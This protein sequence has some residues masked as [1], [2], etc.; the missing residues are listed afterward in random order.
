MLKY[1]TRGAGSP[2]GKQKVYLCTCPNEEKL[3]RKIIEDILS[4]FNCV[5][6]YD[7]EPKKTAALK[8]SSFL[9]EMQLF[10]VPITFRFLSGSNR[11]YDQEFPFA[12]KKHIPILPI[13]ADSSLVDLFNQKCGDLQLLDMTSADSTTL[14]YQEKLKNYLSQIL[15]D[16]ETANKI[17]AAFEAYIFLSYRKKDREY[18]RE[19][20]RLIHR[21]PR[22][23]DTAIWY[24]EY[25][26]PGESFNSAI[27]EALLRCDIFALAVSPNL[28]E[29]G[30]YVMTCEY[31]MAIEQGKPILPVEMIKTDEAELKKKFQGIPDSVNAHD[32]RALSDG[33]L[34]MMQKTVAEELDHSREHLFLIG[35]AYLDGVDVEVDFDRAVS[36]ITSAAL[37]GL[38][39]AQEKLAVMYRNGKAVSRNYE[40]AIEWQKRLVETWR[41]SY[42]EDNSDENLEKLAN[43]LWLLGDYYRDNRCIE[44]AADVYREQYRICCDSRN[45]DSDSAATH[46]MLAAAITLADLLQQEQRFEEAEKVLAQEIRNCRKYARTEKN[47]PAASALAVCCERLGNVLRMNGEP[48]KAKAYYREMRNIYEEN[49]RFLDSQP[50]EIKSKPEFLQK[51]EEAMRN[52]AFSFLRFGDLALAQ[53]EAEKARKFYEKA[54]PI[55]ASLDEEVKTGEARRDLCMCHIRLSDAYEMEQKFDQAKKH[56]L[57]SLEIRKLLA[58]ESALASSQFD[59]MLGN[60][61][62][63]ELLVENKRFDEAIEYLSQVQT[64]GEG[65]TKGNF[66]AQTQR[67]MAAGSFSMGYC[68]RA[69]KKEQEA[70]Q[71]F[72]EGLRAFEELWKRIPT[73]AAEVDLAIAYYR[74]AVVK[75]DGKLLKKSRDTWESICKK[76]PGNPVYEQE[77]R[78]VKKLYHIL[79]GFTA[80]D[81]ILPF[82]F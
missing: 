12:I 72:Q 29:D 68:L 23:R 58:K 82:N 34:H 26:V 76:H 59:L 15:I 30:N 75:H 39:A 8:E 5:V 77:Y 25:L 61:K 50:D 24:D 46:F 66:D 71:C 79:C 11:A 31:P 54:L 67:L 20:M 55:Y 3:G 52:I 60:Y 16:D 33:L 36:L 2:Q 78:K 47:L 22:C 9:G 4:Q 10:V 37:A 49:L 44:E 1:K 42:H 48:Q 40:K 56:A 63:G 45:K 6:W 38:A 41:I 35:L 64:I 32:D 13:L 70:Y 51:R 14:S 65:L 74:L 62:L 27:Q 7:D 43:A 21:R 17:R 81:R 18:A 57:A 28:L 80:L 69:Q 73:N 53:K 19:L